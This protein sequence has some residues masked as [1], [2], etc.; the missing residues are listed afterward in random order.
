MSN[1]NPQWIA[2]SAENKAKLNRSNPH[3]PSLWNQTY[4]LKKILS[5]CVYRTKSNAPSLPQ[6]SDRTFCGLVHFLALQDK[7]ISYVMFLIK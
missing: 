5:I 4:L 7:R 1:H 3:F 2:Q 6:N